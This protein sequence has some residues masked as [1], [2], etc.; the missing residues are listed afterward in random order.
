MRSPAVMG[1]QCSVN[2]TLKLINISSGARSFGMPTLEIRHGGPTVVVCRINP[3]LLQVI[4]PTCRACPQV[5]RPLAYPKTG[6]FTDTVI[7]SS[8]PA[9]VLPQV[10]TSAGKI[11]PGRYHPRCCVAQ[12]AAG[13]EVHCGRLAT[14]IPDPDRIRSGHTG[15]VDP[16][17]QP[18]SASDRSVKHPKFTPTKTTT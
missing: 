4:P 17:I 11:R 13:G 1:D 5:S 8:P 6:L 15:S 2:C 7:M 16:V 18:G 10:F 9:R 14:I 12:V 3:H